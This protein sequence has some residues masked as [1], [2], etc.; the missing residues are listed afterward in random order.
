[1]IKKNLKELLR[2]LKKFKVQTLIVL[3]YKKKNDHRIFH[4]STKLIARDS[5][6][7]EAFKSLDQNIMK[8]IKNYA[9]ED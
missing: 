4:L 5:D 9:C 3:H 7:D 2:E 1:M 6:N 8:K